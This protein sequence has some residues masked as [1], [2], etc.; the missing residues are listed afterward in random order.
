[1][2]HGVDAMLFDEFRQVMSESAFLGA[3]ERAN[4][5]VAVATLLQDGVELAND[6]VLPTAP[7]DMSWALAWSVSGAGRCRPH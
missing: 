4:L 5:N 3:A 2:R 6:S 7:R 1:M